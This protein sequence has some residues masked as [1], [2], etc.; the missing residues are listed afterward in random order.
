MSHG[1]KFC[2]GECVRFVH[3]FV[4]CRQYISI[5]VRGDLDRALGTS[6]YENVSRDIY[7]LAIADDYQWTQK[8]VVYFFKS[9]INQ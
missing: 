6:R 8:V 1:V 7:E 2:V 4:S 5:S 9:A 3:R